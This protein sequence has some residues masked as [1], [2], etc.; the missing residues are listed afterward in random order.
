MKRKLLALIASLAIAGSASA[1]TYVDNNP[2]NVWLNPL[3][4]SYTGTFDLTSDGFDP[5]T[6]QVNSAYVTFTF[7]D[8]IFG[9]SF[10]VEFDGSTVFSN[11]SFFG[12]LNLGDWLG[13]SL[14]LDLNVDGKL[15]YT[16][17]WLSGE[18]WLKNARLEGYAEQKPVASVPETGATL[19]L[20][21]AAF[22]GLAALRR[23]RAA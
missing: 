20:T 13:A 17:Q 6:E 1:V 10:E 14:L 22:V 12:F 16:V 5:S 8:A 2:A 7:W 11:G 19:L 18:F 23:R 3:H 15:S 21:G 4:Q 9:E